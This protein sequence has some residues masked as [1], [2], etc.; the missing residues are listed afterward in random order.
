[1]GL[2]A[3]LQLRYV[4][5]VPFSALRRAGPFI[6]VCDVYSFVF[7]VQARADSVFD[8]DVYIYN[9]QNTRRLHSASLWIF[10]ENAVNCV[11]YATK[12]QFQNKSQ[13]GRICKLQVSRKKIGFYFSTTNFALSD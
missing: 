1:M 13:L 5:L 12:R 7:Y 3:K 10:E 9:T 6:N 2:L 8:S 11:L 4:C